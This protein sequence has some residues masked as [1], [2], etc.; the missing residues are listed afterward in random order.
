MISLH[1][2]QIQPL[3]DLRFAPRRGLLAKANVDALHA[4]FQFPDAGYFLSRQTLVPSKR[5]GNGRV[6]SRECTACLKSAGSAS[7]GHIQ[8]T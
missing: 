5:P 1:S 8:T 3:R 6:G 4:E 7:H 2:L